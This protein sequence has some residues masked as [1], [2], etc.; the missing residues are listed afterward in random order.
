ML[1][2][3][4]I[5]YLISYLNDCTKAYDLGAPKISDE[6]WDKLY[7]ELKELEEK[8]GLIYP[9]SPTQSI[10]Y[11]VV[12]KLVK[13]EHNHS[14]LSLDKTK[15]LEDIKNFLSNKD[16]LAMCKMDGLTCSLTYQDGKL[17]SAE[18]R[19][20]GK[21]GED[22]L[23][24]AKIIGSIPAS[25]SY[26]DKLIID[27]EIICT[28]NNFEEFSSEY[29]NPRNFAAGSIRLLD[30]SECSKRKLTFIPWEVITPIYSEG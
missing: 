10:N 17:V 6:E 9:N 19:G 7:F 26:K 1:D 8:T 16:Y 13:R 3:L 23:H 22:V 14:M 25:I 2:H 21:I 12:N 27:G 20:D 29:K 28:Y 30:S 4:R 11:E 18:T 15:S 24:N 5:I